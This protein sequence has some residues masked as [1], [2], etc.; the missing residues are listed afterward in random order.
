MMMLKFH[1]SVKTERAVAVGCSAIV[2]LLHLS[3]FYHV[4]ESGNRVVLILTK[5]SHAVRRT[6]RCELNCRLEVSVHG[7]V[8]EGATVAPNPTPLGETNWLIFP[9]RHISVKNKRLVVSIPYRDCLSLCRTQSIALSDALAA[10]KKN[11][12]NADERYSHSHP[13]AA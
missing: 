7:P 5:I 13:K 6:V 3:L 12:K 4:M 8:R 1:G 2:R 10:D 11:G 9:K